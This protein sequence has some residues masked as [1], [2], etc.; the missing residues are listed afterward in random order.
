MEQQDGAMQIRGIMSD[1]VFCASRLLVNVFSEDEDINPLS[2]AL[3]I[4]EHVIGLRSRYSKNV[5]LVCRRPPGQEIIGFIEMY[6]PDF[7][8]A[9]QTEDN[10]GALQK[11]VTKRLQPYIA[12]LA[13]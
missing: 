5:I 6:T 3:I 2:R 11:D 7:L 13:V 1:E 9:T 12:N 8:A 10:V 4:A